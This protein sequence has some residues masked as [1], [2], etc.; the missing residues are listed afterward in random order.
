[1]R[2]KFVQTIAG[3][4]A[5]KYINGTFD[6]VGRLSGHYIINGSTHL[7]RLGA[8]RTIIEDLLEVNGELN[9]E[10]TVFNSTVTANGTASF[11]DCEAKEDLV[12]SGKFSASHSTFNCVRAKSAPV[13]FQ[14]CEIDSL[15]MEDASFSIF[16]HQREVIL[17]DTHVKSDI[18]FQGGKPGKV[19]LKGNAFVGGSVINGHTDDNQSLIRKVQ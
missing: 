4:S 14:D 17:K 10:N 15:V 11:D 18:I 5:A 3:A 19:I 13:Q 12:V 2:R 9:A 7:G 1:M 6:F 16:N 8:E